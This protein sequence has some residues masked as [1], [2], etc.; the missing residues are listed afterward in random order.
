M[1]ELETQSVAMPPY[2]RGLG[3][4]IAARV[5]GIFLLGFWFVL[6]AV[7]APFMIA[8]CYITGNENMIYGPARFF[9]RLGL[10][11]V[12]VKV[13]VSGAERLDPHQTYIFTPNQQSFIEVP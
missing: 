8:A 6:I 9:I 10:A 5:R 13:R 3:S 7:L 1:R 11:L 2:S 12:R 4:E